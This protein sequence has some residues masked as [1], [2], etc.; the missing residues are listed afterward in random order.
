[1]AICVIRN[2]GG[3]FGHFEDIGIVVDRVIILE[4][5]RSVAVMLGAICVLNLAYPKGLKYYY[6]FIQKAIIQNSE[7]FVHKVLGLRNKI[8]VMLK[9]T[10]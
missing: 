5:I 6:E 1:M 2:E 8:S 7:R 9:F 4:H 10:P 3:D